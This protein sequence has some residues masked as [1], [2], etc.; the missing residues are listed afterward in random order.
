MASNMI[1]IVASLN[2]TDSVK[3]I[4]GD[5]VTISEQLGADAL[6]ITG[7]LSTDTIERIKEQLSDIVL[8]IG[9]IKI[10]D[11]NLDT[12][13]TKVVAKT[14]NV[15][16][17]LTTSPKIDIEVNA[18]AVESVLDTMDELKIYGVNTDKLSQKLENLGV[19]ITKLTPKITSLKDRDN[20]FLSSF[21]LEGVDK[22]GNLV[23]YVEKYNRATKQFDEGTLTIV[24]DL[25]KIEKAEIKAKNEAEAYQKVMNEFLTMQGKYEVYS[26]KFGNDTELS[27][28]LQN[29]QSIIGEFN[30]TE[31]IEKQREVLIRLDTALKLIKVDIDAIN[32][33]KIATADTNYPA[34]AK[35]TSN[36]K[37]SNNAQINEAK[38]TLNTFFSSEQVSDKATRIKRAIEDTTGELQRFYV[39]VEKGDKSVETLT[40]ALNEQGDAYEYLGKVTREA[41]NSTDFRRRGLDVQKQLNTEG[42]D[43]FIS[44]VQKAG[45]YT[46]DFKTQVDA[47]KPEL[48]KVTDTN[49]MNRFLDNWDLAKAKFQALT[50]EIRKDNAVQ[51]FN[52]KVK[53]L[54]ADMQSYATINDRAVTSTKQMVTSSS[55]YANEWQRMMTQMAKGTD[56]TEQEVK[57]LAAAF[58]IFKKNA[59][60]AGLEGESAFSKFL[61]TFKVL[62]TYISASRMF[63]MIIQQVRSAVT[64]L[65]D[66]DNILTEISKTSDRTADSLRNLGK[67]SFDVASEYGR[68]A[69]DYLLGVQEMS[70]AGFGE[71]QSENLAKL[72]ILAQAAGDMTA[73][74]ANEYII[75]TNAAYKLEGNE[76]RLNKVLD[77]QNYI[78]NHN[79]VNME[80]LAQATKIAA[81]QASASGVAIDELTAA[82]GTMVATTQQGGEQAGRAFKG[83]LM[84]IQQV[85]ASAADIGDGDDDITAE[86]L[87]KYERASAALGVALKEVR[88]GTLQ[89]REPMEVLRDLSE[90]VRKESEGS[91]KVANLVSAVG[92]KFRGNQLIALL[93][94][95]DTYEKMLSE[96]NSESAIASAWKEA[97]KSAN[98]WAGSINKVKNSWS[99]LVNQFADSDNMISVLKSVN[100]ILQ[101]LKESAASGSLRTLSDVF[102]GILKTVSFLTQKLGAI[103]SLLTAIAFAKSLKGNGIFNGE[104]ID[105]IATKFKTLNTS[106]RAYSTELVAA[107]A[108]TIALKAATV[109]LET[110]ISF[111][112]SM[113]ISLAVSGISKLVDELVVTEEELDEVRSKTN[114]GLSELKENTE[115]Y[116]KEA[117]SIASLVAEYEHIIES[118]DSTES[119]KGDLLRIQENLIKQFGD[120]AEG[121]DLVNGKYEDNIKWIKKLSEEE[122][123]EFERKNATDIARAKKISGYNIAYLTAEDYAEVANDV[124]GTL[125]LDSG[126][127]FKDGKQLIDRDYM[128]NLDSTIASLYMVENVSQDILNI[129]REIEGISVKD[130]LGKNTIYFSGQITDVRD[131][132]GQLVD[133][134]TAFIE[135]NSINSDKSNNTLEKI[136]TL[137][138][139]ILEDL[140]KIDYFLANE[141]SESLFNNI[142][143]IAKKTYQDIAHVSEVSGE[144][145]REEWLATLDDM[146]KGSLKSI[147]KMVSA[148]QDL[149]EGKGINANEFWE[150]VEFDEEGLLNGAKLVGDRFYI[151]QEKMI[152]LKD[153]YIQKQIESLEITLQQN[154]ADRQY[155]LGEVEKYQKQLEGVKFIDTGAKRQLLRDLEIAVNNSKAF[156]DQWERN[157]WL[158]QY[159]NQTLGNTVDLQKQLES[160]QKQLNKELTAL[161][162]EL[163]N[164]VKAHEAVIDG[165]IKNLESEL[166]VLEKEKDVL[167]DELD[168]LEKKKDLLEETLDNYEK[169]E[170]Y[171]VKV[172]EDEIKSLEE[173]RDAIKDSYD[174]RI[175][176]LKEENEEREN[177][178]EYAQKLAD[179]EN[180]Q[181]NKRRVYDE[182]RGWRY[183]SVREDVVKAQNELDSYNNSQAI[184]KLERERDNEV[185]AWEKLIKQKEV[186]KEYWSNA[187]K[188]IQD[189]ESEALLI[190]EYG[191][192]VRERITNGDITLLNDFTTKYRAH[193][194]ELQNLTNTEIKLKKAEID[195]KNEDIKASKE[196]IEAWKTYKQEFSTAVTDIKNANEEYMNQIGKIELDESTSLENRRIVFEGFKDKVKGYI[197]EIGAKQ[198]EIDNVTA[199]I[200]NIQGGNWEFDFTVTGTDKLKE[201]VKLIE[202]L[203]QET[204]AAFAAR[205]LYERG[206]DM[207]QE[208]IDFW[209]NQYAHYS[210][211]GNY[212]SGGVVGYTGLAMLHGTPQRNELIFNANDASKLYDMVHNTPNLMAD[213]LNQ[214]Q[215]LSGF[216]LASN[217]V[218]NNSNVS[219][220]IDKI[221]TDNPIDFE[222]QLDKYY[223][224]KLTQ[225]Y[226][227]RN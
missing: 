209:Q 85:K 154:E 203:T 146:Q 180:A 95:W 63:T 111:G 82:V 112:L 21:S 12:E 33:A 173:Q 65:K 73:E 174:E 186:Y 144:K 104:T 27:G 11:G 38:N 91:I 75:A 164:Y 101:T 62:S 199:A 22:D 142:F 115:A 18:E 98:N 202:A 133:K 103:P 37:T 108:K 72:S 49:S 32:K 102:S 116:V 153:K 97:E 132:L 158:I 141:P 125:R 208:D 123:K 206:K 99:A 94:N 105:V 51:N 122:R 137:Y 151:T 68:T 50:A 117:E 178:L 84:N 126:T 148:L 201:A 118:V 166:S 59:K 1:E 134:Y 109:A 136:S 15:L 196:R 42:V 172:L 4:Q 161:N 156:G 210:V 6:Q 29:I 58:A 213:M 194:T 176:A 8:D 64:E 218:S 135:S 121:L 67:V 155:W 34:I 70:R 192:D 43:A 30:N 35:V 3:Q 31:P 90:A 205:Q 96:Y 220:Y 79:A 100:S 78:T 162:K 128:K 184:K 76:E 57:D 182:A 69:S 183:E 175:D 45:L 119:A 120:E 61:G 110:A 226:T 152:E 139:S 170:N 189:E 28:Q 195:A 71:T 185:K 191:A 160:Q 74:M 165:I 217:E 9:G 93:Q 56:L 193:N 41:D 81:S 216:K 225:T 207:S 168:A 26:K 188:E 127:V 214:A 171:V 177:A 13:V 7:S 107:K 113:A 159:L 169:M 219:F 200:E 5:L 20:Q 150:L 114:V 190:E 167:E 48:D 2:T 92:G 187:L 53:K 181:N 24:Q 46:G 129:A 140:E 36:D 212:A 222:R 10:N 143:N 130:T 86:S 227:G 77:S 16:N 19:T 147:S 80:N 163:D 124:A 83:I 198:T 224:T 215:K 52:N 60:A 87:S 25:G 47:L 149:S 131:Q 145:M 204:M 89:L 14:Q 54:S 66:I 40:Y 221:V 39:Q 88:N 223:R 197:D 55:S 211:N 44:K 106:V 17:G 138:S 157:N 179:L 23:K